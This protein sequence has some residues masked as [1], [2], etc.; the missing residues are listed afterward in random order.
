M[1]EA[2]PYNSE[3]LQ[4]QESAGC[5][6]HALNNLLGGTYFIRSDGP[7]Y[8]LDEII[9]AGR[10]L[11]AG[12]PMDLQ[13]VCRYLSANSK[14]DSTIKCPVSENYL[15]DVMAFA[16]R[17]AGYGVN[18]LY[19]TKSGNLPSISGG[20]IGYVFNYNYAH[21]VALRNVSGKLIYKN[22]IKETGD[23]KVTKTQSELFKTDEEA[24]QAAVK[25]SLEPVFVKLSDN[26]GTTFTYGNLP[27]Y[28]AKYG[29]VIQAVLIIKNRSAAVAEQLRREE[30]TVPVPVTDTMTAPIEPVTDTVTAPVE[31][32]T[33]T[34][35]APAT[36]PAE[37]VTAPAPAAEPA[38]EPVTA[39]AEPVTDTAPATEPVTTPAEPV[40]DTVTAPAPAPAPAPTPAPV[41]N[42]PMINLFT[43]KIVPSA[44]ASL[45]FGGPETLNKADSLVHEIDFLRKLGLITE[46]D[47]TVT[48]DPPAA[49]LYAEYGVFS[50]VLPSDDTWNITKI[51]NFLTGTV[52]APTSGQ[53]T[54]DALKK[55]LFLMRD[56]VLPRRIATLTGLSELSTETEAGRRIQAEI[57]EMQTY[58]TQ[59]K[60]IS[61]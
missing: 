53:S 24:Y 1:Y 52:K 45:N 3:Y 33:D 31:P 8:T 19:R 46:T 11:S 25:A 35:P 47:K 39:P 60:N 50:E 48:I 23:L 5:G 42:R 10:D 12:S 27:Q 40:P 9:A 59:L 28:T 43:G 57:N 2:L 14:Y 61:P 4:P 36:A 55:Y 16:L 37:P 34:E 7:A 58:I 38:T 15:A 54:K 44:I 17:A 30:T 18:V 13:R 21:W 20:D 29:N 32:V 49:I 56:T 41:N 22:S 26:S 6:R 51:W